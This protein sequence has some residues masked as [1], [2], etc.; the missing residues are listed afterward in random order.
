M[1]GQAPKQA[2]WCKETPLVK[3]KQPER[4]NGSFGT[5]QPGLSCNLRLADLQSKLDLGWISFH[6]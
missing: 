4:F 2:I 1:S 6:K 3:Q 5:K